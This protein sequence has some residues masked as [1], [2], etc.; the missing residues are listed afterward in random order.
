MQND[1][2]YMTLVKFGGK[3]Y[4]VNNNCSLTEVNY[5]EATRTVEVDDPMLWKIQKN[6]PNG[7][8]YFNST[9]AGF[10]DRQIASDWYRR[11]LDPSSGTGY[12]EETNK[13]GA[14]H[15]DID[16]GTVHTAHGVTYYE[17]HITNR[18][19]VENSTTVSI[20][21]TSTDDSMLYNIYHGDRNGNNYLGVVA[22]PDGTLRLAGQQSSSNAAVFVFATPTKVKEL[23]WKKHTVDHI[24]I[25]INGTAN[26]SIPLA[27]GK[28]YGSTA[29]DQEAP[30]LTISDN[31]KIELSKDQMV[32]QNQLLIKAEDMKRAT[33]SAARADNGKELD[34]AFYITGYSGN[35]AN[36]NSNDQVR[37]EGSF[38]VAD[39]RGKDYENVDEE[40]YK[41]NSL[42]YRDRVKEARKNNIVEYTVTV[43]KPLTYYLIYP[44][45]GQLYDAE[46]KP[47]IIT[48]DVAFSASFNYWDENNE[49][50]ALVN[51]DGRPDSQTGY[52][53]AEWKSGGIDP[54][55]MSGMDFVL[56]GNADDQNSPLTALEITKV[57][58]DENGNR[59][60]LKAPIQNYFDIYEKKN[61]TNDQKNG[62]AGLHVEDN[63]NHPTW[64]ADLRDETIRDGY[65]Y[66]RTKHVTVDDTGSAITFD[67]NATDA[68]Y[69]ITERHDEESL[70][71]TVTDKD[72]NE[73]IYVKTYMETEY[74]RRGDQYDDKVTYPKPVHVTEDYTR[75]SGSYAS[76]PEAQASSPIW[77]GTKERRLPG[78]LR[79]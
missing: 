66:W 74:V 1:G 9:E 52:S 55:G 4:I 49:C 31:I 42:G 12:L 62:V 8:I 57:I 16:A 72:G 78:V 51:P 46:G 63:L 27:Y 11:Y 47:L 6:I 60:E 3:Y 61:A 36:G 44:G 37:I 58:M 21:N 77:G 7:H 53:T 30:I 39:L 45:L 19:N 38:L 2:E 76:I 50:P 67:F 10:D 20:D 5:D 33:I 25:S 65:T 59:I 32:D 54:S 43:V 18:T 24:D 41:N 26:V 68:M 28:Y 73:Y 64:Q 48:V 69:Y 29:G 13:Q 56:G 75:D 14:G 34:D 35:V 23:D 17:H 70:P 22:N 15:V 71:E 40:R 79:L